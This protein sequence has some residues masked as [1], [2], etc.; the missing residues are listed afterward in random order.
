MNPGGNDSGSGN[1]TGGGSGS[2]S[3]SGTG[4]G[5]GSGSGNGLRDNQDSGSKK[6]EP[7]QETKGFSRPQRST[8]EGKR[9]EVPTGCALFPKE[10]LAWPPRSYAER[11]YNITQ[12]TEMPKGG[13][14]AAMEQPDL[15][16]EDLRKF[17]RNLD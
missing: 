14:F 16:I 4:G 17:V 13:H 11:I 12:W 1:G 15:L 6:V 2:G 5:S 9:V 3:G 10:L 8:P 7:E